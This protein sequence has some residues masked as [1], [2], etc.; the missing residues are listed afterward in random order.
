MSKYFVDD[1]PVPIYE[2][3]PESMISDKAPNVIWIRPRMNVEI[4]GRVKSELLKLG[5]DGKTPEVHVGAQQMALLIHNIMRWSGPDLGN[6][7]CTPQIIRKLDPTDPHI[8]KV[9]EAIA[10]RNRRRESPVPNSRTASGLRI[11]GG[12][13]AAL[14]A[15]TMPGFR[16]LET[17]TR[18]SSW[19]SR[20][21]GLQ[22][23]LDDA[24]QTS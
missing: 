18:Q 4:D 13:S 2:F 22:S 24:T 16:P 8:E 19:Q 21:D 9:L 6:V 10:E 17:T 12:S 15:A 14:E 3:D 11:A 20:L 7:P 5:A 1:E 23:K